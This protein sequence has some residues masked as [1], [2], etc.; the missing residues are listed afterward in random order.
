MKTVLLLTAMFL[1]AIVIL[2]LTDHNDASLVVFMVGVG[3]VTRAISRRC[4]R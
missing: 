3:V 4:K 2:T 1:A